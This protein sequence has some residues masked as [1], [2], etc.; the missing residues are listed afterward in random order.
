VE[1]KKK[2]T[3]RTQVTIQTQSGEKSMTPLPSVFSSPIRIDVVQN[4]YTLMA[5]NR[6]QAYGVKDW[7]GHQVA[8][9]S[10][11]TGRAVARIPRVPGSGTSRSGQGAFGNMCRK[12]RMFAPTRVWRKWHKKIS[13]GQRRFATVS[14]LAASSVPALVLARG[15]RIENVNE[16]PLVVSNTD[17]DH[18]A[19]TKDA[20]EFL[21]KINAYED[22]EKV[23]L[24]RKL[25]A[26]NGKSRNRRYI[27]RRGP[28]I[29]YLNENTRVPQAFRN[30]PGIELCNVNRLN[31]LQLA[32]GGH[33]GRF[34]IW[35]EDAFKSLENI[36][37]SLS[38]PSTLKQ[39]FVIPR[40][41]MTNADLSRIINSDEVQSVLR[42]KEKQ[43]R[44]TLKKKSFEKFWCYGEIES[45]CIDSKKK[46][47]SC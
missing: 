39:G 5:K 40:A 29:V 4:V 7:A 34:V 36:F 20:V 13:K 25:R 1:Y 47:N 31:L 17:L 18:I 6:R 24:S 27:Q 10:W 37:G 14:A 41:K 38:S 30:I 35:A 32:P 28:L 12:G 42:P 26:G 2:M 44:T 9:E 43:F 15:H 23:K 19:K 33:L 3:S 21:H 11:G 46:N 8:A 22:I 45:I 16:I